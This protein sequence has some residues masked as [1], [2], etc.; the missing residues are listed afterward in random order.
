[1][2]T[3]Q[4]QRD[5][6]QIGI[7]AL[8]EACLGEKCA[9]MQI[10]YIDVKAAPQTVQEIQMAEEFIHLEKYLEYRQNQIKYN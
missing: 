10:N 7:G 2:D 9:A 8:L 4:K 3:K 5:L 6:F 1:M